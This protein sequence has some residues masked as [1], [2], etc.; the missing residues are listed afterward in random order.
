MRMRRGGSALRAHPAGPPA[1]AAAGSSGGIGRSTS[2]AAE[3]VS[4][5]LRRGQGDWLEQRRRIAALSLSGIGSLGVVAA[6]QTGLIRRP[7]EPPF[8]GLGA[9][10]VDAAGEAYE[11]LKTPDAALGLVSY[12]MTLV[13]AGMGDRTRATSRPW[14]PLA[15][16]AKVLFDAAS[17]IYL[18]LEQGTKHRRFCSWCLAAAATSVA[19]VPSAL[20]EAAAAWRNVRGR[21]G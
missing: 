10:R 1:G 19:M 3:A 20:P 2:T 12:A 14:V 16:A 5:D 17:G 6:Y 21:D 15:L 8:P 9:E 18:T 4:D 7:P 13:L 11:F